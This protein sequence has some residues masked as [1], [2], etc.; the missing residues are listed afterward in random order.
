LKVKSKSSAGT[1]RRFFERDDNENDLR[2]FTQNLKVA[3]DR[4]QVC[5]SEHTHACMF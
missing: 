4:F 1:L 2:D 5:F 3:L